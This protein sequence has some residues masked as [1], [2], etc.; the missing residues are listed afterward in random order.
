MKLMAPAFAA[1]A[2]LATP[3]I[4]QDTQGQRCDPEF[5]SAAETVNLVGLEIGPNEFARRIS[6]CVFATGQMGSALLH[7]EYRGFLAL[8]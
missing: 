6:G 3:A 1:W 5:S 2:V 4:A 8:P 7:C